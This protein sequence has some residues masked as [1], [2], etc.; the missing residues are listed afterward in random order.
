MS[1]SVFWFLVVVTAFAVPAL[2]LWRMVG[3]MGG[4][5]Q[6]VTPA[7]PAPQPT[8][9]DPRQADPLQADEQAQPE[10]LPPA[11]LP[12]ANW[13]DWRGP[14][15]KAYSPSVPATL[16][17]KPRFLWRRSLTGAGLSGVAATTQYVVVADKNERQDQDVFR[18][19]D[20]NTGEQLWSVAY[21]TPTE[22][23][24]T[25]APRATPVI[26]AGFVYL[27][28]AFGDLHCVSLEHSQVIWRRNII[29]DFDAEL[30]AWG[31]CSTPL[32][33]D[34]KLIVNPGAPD[35]AL[36]A[37]GLYAGEVIWKTPGKPAAYGSLILGTFGG[38]R[39]IVGHDAVSLGG[40]DPNDGTRLWTL[41]P[42]VKGE[43]N[44]PTPLDV[45]GRLLVAT[46]KNGT[47]LYGFDDTGRIR[48]TPAA[49]NRDLAPDTSTPVMANGLIF[50]CA[51]GLFCLDPAK[52]LTTRYAVTGTKIFEQ[53]AALIAGNDRVLAVTADGTL[54]LFEAAPDRFTPAARL[55]LFESAEVWSHPALVGNRLYLRT[56]K[57]IT[58]VLLTG[59]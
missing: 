59:S 3:A 47:R 41:M 49:R 13:T 15:R 17:A 35:A 51:A 56:M 7:A 14:A 5:A 10:N 37:L 23:D 25:N 58:C 32:I 19:L 9:S 46:E 12:M 31:T 44:V 16:P 42:E 43:Y 29:E 52:D 2:I 6:P 26:H 21:A 48:S 20:A 27:L 4:T 8:K 1:K 22:M 39:Q 11:P 40:W 33:V 38:K 55:Q 53:Y 34:D 54:I 28:G 24:F 50:G 36:V 30:P 18:C 57:E 45:G